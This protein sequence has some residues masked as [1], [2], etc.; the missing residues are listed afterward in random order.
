MGTQ[1][2]HVVSFKD[3]GYL[4]KISKA[5]RDKL[6]KSSPKHT[7]RKHGARNIALKKLTVTITTLLSSVTRD[8]TPTPP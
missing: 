8:T 4:L 7:F 1:L 3:K 5:A 6:L 2:P